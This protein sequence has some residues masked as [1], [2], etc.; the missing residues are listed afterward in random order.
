MIH[1]A[2]ITCLLRFQYIITVSI[3]ELNRNR[4]KAI[5]VFFFKFSYKGQNFPANVYRFVKK[6]ELQSVVGFN[7]G[8][9][10]NYKSISFHQYYLSTVTYVQFTKTNHRWVLKPLILR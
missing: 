3:L 8:L 7:N 9:P 1:K 5:L 4:S 6:S 10:Q 2:K